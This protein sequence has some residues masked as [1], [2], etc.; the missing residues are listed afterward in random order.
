LSNHHI[1]TDVS[2]T[3]RQRGTLRRT[4]ENFVD[5]FEKK[6]GYKARVIKRKQN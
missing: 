6:N 2:T 4:I 3:P 5:D 1:P